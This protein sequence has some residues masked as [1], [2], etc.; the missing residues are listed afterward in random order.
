MFPL[1]SLYLVPERPPVGTPAPGPRAP[2]WTRVCGAPA[3][4]PL[5]DTMRAIVL[6]PTPNIAAALRL[7]SL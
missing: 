1:V 7:G 3:A 2:Y 6:L 4:P 5:R